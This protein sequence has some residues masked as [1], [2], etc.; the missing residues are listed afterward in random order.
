MAS[1]KRARKATELPSCLPS[2]RRYR[3]LSQGFV[4]GVERLPLRAPLAHLKHGLDLCS[5]YAKLAGSEPECT[6]ALGA[7]GPR[8]AFQ[9]R[10]PP[11]RACCA[12]LAE[13]ALWQGRL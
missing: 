7:I 10:N 2:S 1:L 4:P 8:P 3:Y 6:N 5:A 12:N 9:V 11:R 13:A